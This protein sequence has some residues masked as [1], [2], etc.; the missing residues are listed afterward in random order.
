MLVQSQWVSIS[1]ASN[2]ADCVFDGFVDSVQG[3]VSADC[4][5][6]DR[7]QHQRPPPTDLVVT[8]LHLLI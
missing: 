7:P 3:V 6:T 4:G 2:P 5:S 8:L 1:K